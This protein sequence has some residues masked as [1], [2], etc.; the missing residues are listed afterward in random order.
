MKNRNLMGLILLIIVI[1][2]VT[3]VIVYNVIENKSNEDHMYDFYA[4]EAA[5]HVSP[6][7]IRKHMAQG[8]DSFILVDLRSEEEYVEEHIITAVNVPAYKS[9]DKSD[10]GAV[11]RI[12]GEFEKLIKNNP[13]KELIVYC[14]SG[15]C[16]TGRKVGK[17]LADRG[18][19]VKHLGI[20]WN[21]WRYHWTIWNH[22][23]EWDETDV[24]DYVIG[25]SEPGEMEGVK[26]VEGCVEG[27]FGC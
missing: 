11:E 13:G 21:E 2:S 8:D 7:H 1:S 14:Y 10:Y 22:E 26:K 3:S 27:G 18:I 16:M 17:M 23:H 12:V 9:R 5:V 15:P 25:G 19:Y 4:A 6:H 24:M 20:G